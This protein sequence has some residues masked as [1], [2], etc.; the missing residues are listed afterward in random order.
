MAI[1]LRSEGGL[2]AFLANRE[3]WRTFGVQGQGLFQISVALW[4]PTAALLPMMLLTKRDESRWKTARRL[5]FLCVCLVPVFL[6]GFRALILI[7]ILQGIAILHYLRKRISVNAFVWFAVLLTAVLTLYGVSRSIQGNASELV[8][9]AGSQQALDYVLFRTPGTDLVATILSNKPSQHFEYGLRGVIESATI[10]IPR[11]V[12]PGKPVSWGERFTTTFFGDYLFMTGIVR[13]VYGGVNPTAIGYFYL[14][15]G[16]ISVVIGMF[17]VGMA[18]KTFYLYGIRNSGPNTAF[19]LFILLWSVPIAMADA[20]QNALNQ[21]V[22]TLCCA[23][24]PI[25]YLARQ[26]N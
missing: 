24:L 5:G 7:P 20:P 16:W 19:L 11:G 10:V 9:A 21:I 8:E 23:W 3:Y 25:S 26:R 22:I 6:L 18:T 17:I 15:S 13:E 4:L 1:F 2:Q 12:W 14:Q